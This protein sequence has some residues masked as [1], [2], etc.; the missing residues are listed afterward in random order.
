MN[1]ETKLFKD[2]LFLRVDFFEGYGYRFLEEQIL[3]EGHSEE[4][5]RFYF[6][7]KKLE[8]KLAFTFYPSTGATLKNEITVF[9][10]ENDSTS[11]NLPAFLA[12][13]ELKKR[14]SYEDREKYFFKVN[15]QNLEETINQQLDRIIEILSTDMKEL[16]TT[17]AWMS[18]PQVHPFNE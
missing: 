3:N 13:Q 15:P 7:N 11:I 1:S 14:I 18:I 8:K 12:Y 10:T 2:L 5:A 4:C 17:E 6:E 16:F 9:I